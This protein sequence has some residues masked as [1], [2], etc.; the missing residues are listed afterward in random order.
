M[1]KVNQS[2]IKRLVE[3]AIRMLD[4]NG[5]NPS[6]GGTWV[7]KFVDVSVTFEKPSRWCTKTSYQVLGEEVGLWR[8]YMNGVSHKNIG[9]ATQIYTPEQ[10]KAEIELRSRSVEDQQEFIFSALTK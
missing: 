8:G 4:E 3:T 6:H 9:K 5:W 7:S 1:K 10:L 2:H